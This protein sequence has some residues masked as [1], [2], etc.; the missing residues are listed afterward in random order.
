MDI[1]YIAIQ[2]IIIR[3]IYDSQVQKQDHVSNLMSVTLVS[4]QVIR[5][6]WR[7]AIIGLEEAHSVILN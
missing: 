5:F 2:T 4:R 1:T 6:L 3:F 7:K